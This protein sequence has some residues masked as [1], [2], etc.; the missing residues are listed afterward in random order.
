LY[1]SITLGKCD[2]L[3]KDLLATQQRRFDI[4]SDFTRQHKA[5]QDALI[6][7][8]TVLENT[9]CDLRDQR[10][11]SRIALE[12]TGKER[13]LILAQKDA[14]IEEQERRTADMAEEFERML[15]ETLT[16]MGGRL[17]APTAADWPAPRPTRP[18]RTSAPPPPPIPR[19]SL[20]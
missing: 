14:E 6:D 15:R 13:D 11:L 16:K 19:L 10:E 7:R 20:G 2:T 4:V 18:V 5:M 17:D 9:A 12:E 8:I 3:E 1:Y